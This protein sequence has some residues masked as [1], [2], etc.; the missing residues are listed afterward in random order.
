MQELYFIN[1]AISKLLQSILA[2]YISDFSFLLICQHRKTYYIIWLYFA[3][4]SHAIDFDH[5]LVRKFDWLY[6]YIA[7]V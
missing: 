6:I 4:K 2:V 3:E 7:V 5:M 1:F